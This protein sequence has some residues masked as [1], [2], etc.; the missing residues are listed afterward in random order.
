MSYGKYTYGKPNILWG[1]G[2]AKLQVGNFCSTA[3]NVNIY[4][5]G[6]H[7][8]DWVST[9]PFG[10][11][12]QHI[13]NAFNGVGHPATKGDVIIGN[14]VWIG[15]NVTIMS[16]VTIGDGA[17]IANNSHVV[18]DIDP[19]S[20]VGGNPAKLI[21]NRFSDVQIAKLLEIKWWGWG[22]EKINRYSPL[23]CNNDIDAFIHAAS[24]AA[25]P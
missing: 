25:I 21:R 6:N 4:L 16:G 10:H 13:F 14:D 17:V 9:Y 19:Y 1:G 8:T 11:I 18:K 24:F 23:L 5:G 22:D 7:R 20:I 12:H 2:D 3:S 15:S